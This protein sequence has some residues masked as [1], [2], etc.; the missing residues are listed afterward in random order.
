MK[1][2]P[3][4]PVRSRPLRL[5]DRR[6][7]DGAEIRIR[8]RREHAHDHRRDRRGTD[9]DRRAGARSRCRDRDRR[10]GGRRGG[11]RDRGGGTRR[12][13]QQLHR[14]RGRL[15][16]GPGLEP[17]DRALRDLLIPPVR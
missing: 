12:A 9:R 6:A 13:G 8:D 14:R 1:A 2:R 17:D 10:S 15:Q 11:G 3:D 7:R 4:A 5:P 16:S